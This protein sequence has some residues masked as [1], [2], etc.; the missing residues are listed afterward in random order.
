MLEAG[1]RETSA[2]VFDRIRVTRTP[3]ANQ[4]AV[5]VAI[6]ARLIWLSH[7]PTDSL[8]CD[9][10]PI[11]LETLVNATCTR[12]GGKGHIANDCFMIN[13]DERQDTAA[14][15][16]P[17]AGSNEPRRALCASTSSC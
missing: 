2:V 5:A 3:N 15:A 10:A 14:T 1:N 12:C 17:G 6:C 9:S 7:S 13:I 8:A 11:Q 16:S 4:D